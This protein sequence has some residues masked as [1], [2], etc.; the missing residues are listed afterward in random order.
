MD[1]HHLPP[2][3]A[4]FYKNKAC[5]QWGRMLQAIYLITPGRAYHSNMLL[6]LDSSPFDYGYKTNTYY[7]YPKTK[8][9]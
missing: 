5:N 4:F 1:I 6:V 2:T 8:S 9:E 3:D 7:Y